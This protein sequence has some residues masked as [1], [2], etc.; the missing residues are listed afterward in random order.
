MDLSNEQT[1]RIE[2]KIQLENYFESYFVIQIF[3]KLYG[4]IEEVI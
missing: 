2:D 4:P 3:L 1:L